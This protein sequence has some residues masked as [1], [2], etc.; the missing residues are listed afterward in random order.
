MRAARAET[1]E[2]SKIRRTISGG[3]A[4]RGSAVEEVSAVIFWGREGEGEESWREKEGKR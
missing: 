2:N 4:A 1:G 3:K